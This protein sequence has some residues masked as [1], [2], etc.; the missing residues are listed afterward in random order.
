[1]RLLCSSFRQR[2]GNSAAIT[3]RR[4]GVGICDWDPSV[5]WEW[6]FEMCKREKEGTFTW[7]RGRGPLFSASTHR[8]SVSGAEISC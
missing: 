6:R 3:E 2:L 4:G 5:G 1:M 8:V 7:T